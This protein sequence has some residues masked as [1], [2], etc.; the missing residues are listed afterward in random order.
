M[1]THQPQTEPLAKQ[2]TVLSSSHFFSTYIKLA[3]LELHAVSSAQLETAAH[4]HFTKTHMAFHSPES[5][6]G[7]FAETGPSVNSVAWLFMWLNIFFQRYTN[8]CNVSNE[9][10]WLR[11]Q[12][13]L[14]VSRDTEKRRS[15]IGLVEVFRDVSPAWNIL[16]QNSQVVQLGFTE[17]F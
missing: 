10:N 4:R 15:K 3:I 9:A 2:T 8:T 6:I 16:Q 11:N 5:T 7:L 1:A 14:F 12:F 17:A 13:P